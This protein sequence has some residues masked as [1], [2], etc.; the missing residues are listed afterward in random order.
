MEVREPTRSIRDLFSE[1]GEK[2]P[3]KVQGFFS[4]MVKIVVRY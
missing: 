4:E 1:V 3:A 2:E